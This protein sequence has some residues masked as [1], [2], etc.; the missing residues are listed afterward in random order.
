MSAM[1]SRMT[2]APVRL[3]DYVPTADHR[4]IMS[5][6]SWTDFESLLAIRGERSAPRMAYLDGVVE[7]MSP[8]RDHERIKSMLGRAVEAYCLERG[9]DISPF[10]S[11][12]V[13]QR[14]KEAG[15]EPDEC[16]IFGGDPK[17]KSWPDLV[18][19]VVWTS[20]GIGKLEIYRRL[21][22]REVWFWEDSSISVH[23]LVGSSY[24]ARTRSEC[25]PDLDLSFLCELADLDTLGQIH[26]A[27][28][29]SLRA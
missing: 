7:I 24:E 5:N 1:T 2:S 22:I 10:G 9:I 19:E 27:V 6:R 18:I 13:E 29:R 17:A 21:G 3:G 15:A 26:D 11:W 25:L 12:L 23:V 20:G 14:V 8:S 4:I 16:Y 28:R